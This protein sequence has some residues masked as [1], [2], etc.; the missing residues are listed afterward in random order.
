MVQR[1]RQERRGKAARCADLNRARRREN[2]RHRREKEKFRPSDRAGVMGCT[3]A[4][5]LE[6]FD[7]A[8]R[9]RLSGSA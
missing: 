7:L 9:R 2:A 6:K 3:S 1:S 8:W 5:L 4:D